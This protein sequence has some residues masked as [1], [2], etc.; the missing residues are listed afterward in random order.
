MNDAG[1]QTALDFGLADFEALPDGCRTL[2]GSRKYP[3][4]VRLLTTCSTL[5]QQYNKYFV[6]TEWSICQLLVS[7]VNTYSIFKVPSV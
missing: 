7:G 1:R 4:L 6:G 2:A 3:L 5:H